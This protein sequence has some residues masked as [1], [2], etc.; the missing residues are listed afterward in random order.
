MQHGD[1]VYIPSTIKTQMILYFGCCL[2]DQA[3]RVV[4]NISTILLKY[5]TFRVLICHG[6]NEKQINIEAGQLSIFWDKIG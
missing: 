1:K 5:P 3:V 4:L 2:A 6:R